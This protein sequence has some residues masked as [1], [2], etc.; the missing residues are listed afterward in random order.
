MF[1][2]QQRRYAQRRRM[3]DQSSAPLGVS[4]VIPA[5]NE[6]GR[7]PATLDEIVAYLRKTRWDWEVRIVDDGSGDDTA[8]VV[9]ACARQEPR[10]V[11]Q[12]EPH[13]GK[14]A[15][16]KAGLLAARREFRFICDADLSMPIHELPRF[17][18]STPTSPSARAKGSARGAWANRSAVTSS[19]GCSTPSCSGCCC[20]A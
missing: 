8:A 5:F 12:R 16:V 7:L 20:P 14:G 9:E 19:D 17:L 6:A 10:V 18:T 13:G 2:D 1:G 4:I 15:A 3:T 11:L